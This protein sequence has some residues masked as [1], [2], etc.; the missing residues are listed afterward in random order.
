MHTQQCL[1]MALW[2]P[3]KQWFT[4]FYH[5]Q[6][7]SMLW[8]QAACFVCCDCYLVHFFCTTC[9]SVNQ[10]EPPCVAAGCL[11]PQQLPPIRTTCMVLERQNLGPKKHCYWSLSL[12]L[13]VQGNNWKRLRCTYQHFDQILSHLDYVGWTIR[14]QVIKVEADKSRITPFPR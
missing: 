12:L 5:C 1:S 14:G 8:S 11:E 2:T 3:N 13:W 9:S 6:V 4:R 7:F 10:F